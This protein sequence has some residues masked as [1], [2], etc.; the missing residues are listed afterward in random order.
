MNSDEMDRDKDAF[1]FGV[2]GAAF[3]VLTVATI[4]MADGLR[5]GRR[6]AVDTGHFVLLWDT[7][8][9]SFAVVS[10]VLL[11]LASLVAAPLAMG[12]LKLAFAATPRLAV[13]P[14]AVSLPLFAGVAIAEEQPSIWVAVATLALPSLAMAILGQSTNDL[15]RKAVFV[16]LVI[17]VVMLMVVLPSAHSCSSA[18]DCYRMLLWTGL[19]G[20]GLH[21]L[22][23]AIGLAAHASSGS[24]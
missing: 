1:S 13:A 20:T 18:E 5:D 2:L 7:S 8:G 19:L 11:S 22:G 23:W 4:L 12:L 21:W 15:L 3:A 14:L 17:H 24:T 6:F 16:L 10:W 9:G